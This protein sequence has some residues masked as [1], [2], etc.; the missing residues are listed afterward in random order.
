MVVFARVPAALVVLAL[1]RVPLVAPASDS[2]P[3][4]VLVLPI[5]A[6]RR[7]ATSE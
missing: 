7:R 3:L 4:V 6:A 1:L 5:A 2:V